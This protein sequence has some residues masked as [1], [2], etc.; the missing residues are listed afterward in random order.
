MGA[1]LSHAQKYV[2]GYAAIWP[3]T[4]I[5]LVQSLPQDFRPLS[6]YANDYSALKTLL[7]QHDIDLTKE[8][9]GNETFV[10]TMSNGGCWGI[11]ALLKQFP[12]DAILRPRALLL[13]SC[14]GLARYSVTLKAFLI[15]GKYRL[16]SK[17]IATVVI[18]IYYC[19]SV[20]VNT[21]LGRDPLQSL[22]STLIKQIHAQ[23]RAYV[24]SKD[25]ELILWKDVISHAQSAE[26]ANQDTQLE[27]FHHS[28]H[29]MHVRA[30][31]ER[32]WRIVQDLWAPNV[33]SRDLVAPEGELTSENEKVGISDSSDVVSS[34]ASI[35]TASVSQDNSSIL[36]DTSDSTTT[37]VVEDLDPSILGTKAYWDDIYKRECTNFAENNEDEG[38]IWFGEESEDK[39]V[40][41]L[42]GNF[43]QDKRLRVLDLGTGN[44]HLLFKLMDEGFTNW[45]MLGIDYSE[46]SVDL[47]RSIAKARGFESINFKVM[48]FLSPQKVTKDITNFDIVLDKG[49]FDAI[50]L[51]DQKTASGQKLNEVYAKSVARFMK[52]GSKL[53]ITS[54][55]WTQDELI[56]KLTLDKVLKVHAYFKKPKNAFSFGGKTGST[57]SSVCFA[58]A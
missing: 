15:A 21:A 9:D 41:Y 16:L 28:A 50:S 42:E 47:A 8:T 57:T 31:E 55:N 17:A 46:H 40:D 51:S 10:A 44:G 14:P 27:E 7:A 22:R 29:V 3:S 56:Q 12:K 32:Y 13:D 38:E 45:D 26:K 34:V 33:P 2:N 54:C 18:T 20:L 49:T 24:Y 5:I 53:V 43:K 39:I 36:Q 23:R 35:T 19:L 37:A 48:D 25:D 6:R 30:D 58:L 11:S 1:R 4:P 52:P